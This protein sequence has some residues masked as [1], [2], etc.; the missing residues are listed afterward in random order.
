MVKSTLTYRICLIK[1]GVLT[2]NKI[3]INIY[4]YIYFVSTKY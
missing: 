4:N 3:I 1:P 2:K